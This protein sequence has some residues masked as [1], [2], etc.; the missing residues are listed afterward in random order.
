M[1]T[2]KNNQIINKDNS[3]FLAKSQNSF[4]KALKSKQILTRKSIFNSIKM[5][6]TL[7]PCESLNQ[8]FYTKSIFDLNVTSRELN[9]SF[10]DLSSQDK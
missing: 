9:N 6:E 2:P 4:G 8:T 7:D 1:N 5:D 10:V 3:V